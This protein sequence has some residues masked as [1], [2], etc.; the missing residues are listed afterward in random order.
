M[1]YKN[2]MPKVSPTPRPTFGDMN[3]MMGNP[4][5]PAPSAMPTKSP[6]PRPSKKVMNQILGNYSE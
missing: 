5:R 4:M 2:K 1:N 3:E 6:K